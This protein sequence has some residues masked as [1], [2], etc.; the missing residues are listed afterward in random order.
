MERFNKIAI[1]ALFII[2]ISCS[3]FLIFKINSNKNNYD[4]ELYAEI[5]EEFEA[6]NKIDFTNIADIKILEKNQSSYKVN[7]TGNG[8]RVI[9]SISIP[10]ISITYPVISETTEEY[11]KIAP[12]KLWGPNPNEE[13]NLC[14]IG[15]NWENNA[16]FSNLKKL[17]NNDIVKIK[18]NSGNTVQYKIYDKYTVKADDLECT[19]QETNGKTE[20]TLITCTNNK[21]KRLILKG[22]KI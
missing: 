4:E 7:A 19:S 15:H 11:L 18:D 21:N 9:A 17:E 8:Y 13:G 12:T 5:Y 22:T 3:I 14:I 2:I 10:K 6:L 20:I 16:L 1:Y